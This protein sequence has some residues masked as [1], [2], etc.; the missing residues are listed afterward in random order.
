MDG[1][2]NTVDHWATYPTL[3]W[4][5]Y[6]S[7]IMAIVKSNQ[8]DRSGNNTHISMISNSVT[9][10][11]SYTNTAIAGNFTPILAETPF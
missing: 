3:S 7:G 10:S 2:W 9:H 8:Q 6:Y 1:L 5:S 4:I 11:R